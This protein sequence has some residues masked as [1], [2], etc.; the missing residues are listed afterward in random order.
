MQ[1]FEAVVVQHLEST[2][3]STPPGVPSAEPPPSWLD[4]LE[5]FRTGAPLPPLWGPIF[6]PLRTPG[7][8]GLMI[9]G[10]IGQSLD[11]RIATEMGDSHYINE[12]A[13]LEH[14]HRLRSLADAV[15]VGVGT[16]IADDPQLTVRRVEGPNPTRVVLD[17][18]GRLPVSAKLLRDDGVR[19]VVLTGAAAHPAVATGAEVIALPQTARGIAAE[20]IRRA[21]RELGFRRVLIEGGAV[22]LSKFLQAGCLDRLHVLI[23]PMILGS[24][25]PG[26][27]LPAIA[28]VAEAMPVIMR[29]F[30]LGN[31]VLLDCDLDVHA[32]AGGTAKKST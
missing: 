15:L 5:S 14:L 1:Q 21:L 20:A 2:R 3:V 11:G 17:P 12:A 22:T 7:P 4:F 29:A 23:A 26:I 32:A 18:N 6:E 31:E 10:Q 19:R 30:G 24:G 25:R 27:A 28:R 13:G 9:V 8:D 16:A